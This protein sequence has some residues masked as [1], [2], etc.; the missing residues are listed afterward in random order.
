MLPSDFE[1]LKAETRKSD[2]GDFL[3]MRLTMLTKMAMISLASACKFAINGSFIEQS[4]RSNS[5]HNIDS[6]AS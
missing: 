2:Y 1:T 3:R 6:S 4:S 5:N